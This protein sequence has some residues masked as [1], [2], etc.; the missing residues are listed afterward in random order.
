L[1]DA[2]RAACGSDWLPLE[3]DIACTDITALVDAIDLSG[4]VVRAGQSENRMRFSTA[5]L[6]QQFLT[7]TG[8]TMLIEPLPQTSEARIV[9]LLNSL[10][11]HYRPT[12]DRLA[13]MFDMSSRSLQRRLEEE[14]VTF[15]EVMTRWRLKQSLLLLQ[16]P[17]MQINE[18][19]ERLHY[20]TSSHFSRS[21]RRWTGVTPG[22][23]RDAAAS[24]AA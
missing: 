14:G 15:S 24:V 2:F 7:N 3:L 13:S 6:G 16:A 20:S 4:V 18:I 12:Q 11:P 8:S 9:Q 19:A 10:Q 1:L 22:Q 23:Y 5:D 17:H 21:F